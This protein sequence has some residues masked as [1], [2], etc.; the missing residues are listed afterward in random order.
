[1]WSQWPCPSW[2]HIPSPQEWVDV[3]EA[4]TSWWTLWTFNTSTSYYNWW[5]RSRSSWWNDF[6]T[7][8][9]L[10]AAGRRNSTSSLSDLGTNGNY[11]SSTAHA[12]T[13]SYARFLTFTS[14]TVRPGYSSSRRRGFSI[15]CFKD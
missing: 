2:Y 10:P 11:W 6:R 1:M 8:L 9:K 7:A 4:W 3:V 15:R 13:A 5:Y 14:S 12:S